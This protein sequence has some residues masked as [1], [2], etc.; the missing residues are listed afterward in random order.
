MTLYALLVP[1]TAILVIALVVTWRLH[2]AA[3]A[4][5]HWLLTAAVLCAAMSPLLHATAPAWGP[6][7]PAMPLSSPLAP[8]I[9]GLDVLNV[10]PPAGPRADSSRATA[11]SPARSWSQAL[12]AVWAVG[13]LGS[14]SFLALGLWRLSHMTRAAVLVGSGAWPDAVSARRHRHQVRQPIDVRV[15]D[16]ASM[17]LVWG[18]RRSAILIP[19]AALTWSAPRI[20]AVVAHEVAHVYRHDWAWQLVSEFACALYW[21]HPLAWCA[22]ARLRAE[23]DAACDDM[24]LRSGAD[25]TSYAGHLIAIARDCNTGVTVPAP[26]VVRAST[27]ERR[28]TAML[29]PTRD[30]RP[31][32]PLLR[33]ATLG[34]ALSATVLVSGLAAQSFVSMTGT[35]VDASRGVL[36]NVTLVLTNEQTGAKYEIKTDRAGRYEF[37]GLPPGQYVLDADLPGFARFNARVTVGNRHVEQDV[38]MSIGTVR[39]SITVAEDA[40]PRV[41]DPEVTRRVEES[42]TKRAAAPCPEGPSDGAVRMGGNLRVPLKFR[43]VRPEYPEALRGTSGAVVLSARI[44]P[45]GSVDEV[46]VVESTHAA[47]AQ[48]AIDAVRQWEFGAT[49]LNCERV[50]TPM[51]V[52]VNFKAR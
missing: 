43:D 2:K 15:M 14:L 27:L 37:V 34:L 51:Q 50:A 26:A 36:P 8:V 38:V 39:E 9:T 18:A 30:R 32:S 16:R 24:V 29:D 49:L 20:E 25:A 48:S 7:M 40:V 12:I 13:A 22:R 1:G 11:A 19:R 5:R 6:A 23:S 35:F 47:F 17:P 44:A 31:L 33:S 3:A 41:P 42:R 21:F 46:D 52:T 4:L 28:L 10:Q 45:D